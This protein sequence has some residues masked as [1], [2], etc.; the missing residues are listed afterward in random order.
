[1]LFKAVRSNKLVFNAEPWQYIYLHMARS[2][3]SLRISPTLV[4]FVQYDQKHNTHAHKESRHT[5]DA[6]ELHNLLTLSSLLH[7]VPYPAL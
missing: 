7:C 1:M 6:T 3:L 4:V 2:S 5:V